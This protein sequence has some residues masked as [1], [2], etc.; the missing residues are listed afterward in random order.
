M[1]FLSAFYILLAITNSGEVTLVKRYANA[2]ECYVD[3]DHLTKILYKK[4]DYSVIFRCVP[5]NTRRFNF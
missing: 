4:K 3:E 5:V 1:Y 2:Q